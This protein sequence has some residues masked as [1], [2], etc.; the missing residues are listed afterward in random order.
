MAYGTQALTSTI[1]SRRRGLNNKTLLKFHP[2]LVDGD[3]STCL[4]LD[5]V[6]KQTWFTWEHLK[7]TR[8][9]DIRLRFNQT[10]SY[11]PKYVLK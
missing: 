8:S 4:N 5:D 7:M 6:K 10:G 1:V 3:F 2:E 11:M 9:G